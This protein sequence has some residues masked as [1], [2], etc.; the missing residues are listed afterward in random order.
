[1]YYLELIQRFWEFNKEVKISP[2]EI[3]L[4]LYLLKIGHDNNRYDF[5]I[6]DIELGR[7][8][9]LTSV[10]INSTKKRLKSLGLIQFQTYRGLPCYYRLLLDYPFDTDSKNK[11]EDEISDI[12]N[13]RRFTFLKAN[14]KI[15]IKNDDIGSV[16]SIDEFIGYAKTLDG[17]ESQLE[18]A[19]KQ[20]YESWLN[21]GWKNTSNRPISNWQLT[22][23]SSLPFI[24]NS[25][26]DNPMSLQDIPDIKY[27]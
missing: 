12:E 5:K 17:F 2:T 11:K 4:Y 20:K 27:P 7:Q 8:L 22:L 23:K 6:S 13:S 26:E 18:P 25:G 1:M 19:I 21:K 24:K 15:E 14:T 16:P 3:S 10:T 9:R